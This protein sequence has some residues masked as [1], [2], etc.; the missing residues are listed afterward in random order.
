MPRYPYFNP[1]LSRTEVQAN[2]PELGEVVEL[3]GDSRLAEEVGVGNVTLAM[4]RPA[5]GPDANIHQLPDFEAAE[6]IEEK[7]L[8]MGMMAK[9]S[10]YFSPDAVEEFYGGDPKTSML[11]GKPKDPVYD[12]RWL[13]FV[14][15]MTSGPVTVFLL[16]SPDGD[17][18]P[19]W[20]EHVGHWNIDK[21]K[22]PNTIRGSL[23][24]NN[25]NN[26]V[27]GSDSIESVSR[28]LDI[29]LRNLISQSEE[30]DDQRIYA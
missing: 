3:L 8:G 11:E 2:D 20:R 18:I 4:I 1:E 29:I 21:N 22:D 24:V 16:H 6:R 27:H 10:F 26:L 7:I 9:F 30:S 19:L 25:F 23:G 15:F 5:V 14:D 13:E 12:N 28:E 17:A